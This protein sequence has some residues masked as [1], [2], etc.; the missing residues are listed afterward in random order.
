MIRL[1][2]LLPL[3][4]CLIFGTGGDAF[5]KAELGLQKNLTLEEAPLDMA[6]SPD[7]QKLFLLLAGGTVQIYS[8]AGKLEDTLRVDAGADRIEVSPK[9]DRLYL[10]NSKAGTLQITAVDYIQ[11]INTVGS[12]FKGPENAPV[13]VAV[14]DDFQ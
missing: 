14:F 4:L 6:T 5:G 3:A 2:T 9:G 10:S 12:P 8:A 7:G 13:V 11:N 1:F